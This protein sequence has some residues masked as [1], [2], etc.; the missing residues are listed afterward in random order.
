MQALDLLLNRSSFNQLGGPAPSDEALNNILKAGLRA[1]DHGNLSPFKF[2][3]FKDEALNDLGEIFA[4]AAEQENAPAEKVEKAKNMPL[5]AP[6]VIAVIASVTQ[7]HKIPEI[8]QIITAGCCVHGMQMAAV[9]QGYQGIWRTGEFA[10]HPHVKSQFKLKSAD[11]IVGYL[12]IGTAKS[13]V[14]VKPNKNISDF[15][16]YW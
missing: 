3:V 8:E 7:A 13:Q 14:P 2:I 12:Y 1:P 11:Q 9:A 16:Q 6:L 5:R 15:V 10:Y 4:E